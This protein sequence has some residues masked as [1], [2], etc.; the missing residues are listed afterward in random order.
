MTHYGTW[1]GYASWPQVSVANTF[2][3]LCQRLA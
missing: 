1:P 2:C 3:T